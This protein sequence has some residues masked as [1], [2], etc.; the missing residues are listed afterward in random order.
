MFKNHRPKGKHRG[1]YQYWP[2]ANGNI[3]QNIPYGIRSIRITPWV[4]AELTGKEPA[5]DAPSITGEGE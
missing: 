2:D 5:I 4:Y 1:K 3:K